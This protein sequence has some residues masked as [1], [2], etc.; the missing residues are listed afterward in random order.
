M[1]FPEPLSEGDLAWMDKVIGA[2]PAAIGGM[3]SLAWGTDVS[4]R[5]QGYQ[6]GLVVRFRDAAA[7]QAYQ[8][9]PRHQELVQWIRERGGQVLAFD[10]PVAP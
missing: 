6:F 2:F 3:E 8:G 5:A 1:R 4:G 9:H 10:F 7:A